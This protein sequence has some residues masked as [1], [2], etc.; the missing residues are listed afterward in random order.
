M[1]KTFRTISTGNW[2]L[3]VK[4]PRLRTLEKLA[5]EAKRVVVSK[6]PLSIIQPTID[7]SRSSR[8]EAAIQREEATDEGQIPHFKKGFKPIYLYVT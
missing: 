1:V 6:T 8:I 5:E 3:G 7:G 4:M 2:Q